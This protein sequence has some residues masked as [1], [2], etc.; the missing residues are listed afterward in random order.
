M[1]HTATTFPTWFG[2]R[3]RM[4][5]TR[6]ARLAASRRSPRARPLVYVS[7]RLFTAPGPARKSM[8]WGRG[9]S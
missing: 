6:A 2:Q 3:G 8:Q 7:W 1:V 9:Q 5:P 4:G